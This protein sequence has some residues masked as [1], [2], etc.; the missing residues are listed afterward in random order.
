MCTGDGLGVITISK[1]RKRRSFSGAKS[2]QLR[3]GPP[4]MCGYRQIKPGERAAIETPVVLKRING[5]R[6]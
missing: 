2:L 5:I 4:K 3:H 6:R 1:R